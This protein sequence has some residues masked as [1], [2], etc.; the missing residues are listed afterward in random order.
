MTEARLDAPQPGDPLA[1]GIGPRIRTRRLERHLSLRELARRIDLS[2]SAVSQIE[3]GRS[4]PSV[5]TLYAIASELGISADDLLFEAGSAATP[6]M[7]DG[8]AWIG[9]RPMVQRGNSRRSIELDSGVRWDRLTPAHEEDLEFLEVEYQVGGASTSSNQLSRHPGRE[10]GVVLSGC[11]RV[12]LAFEDIE[13]N[14]GDSIAFDS[15]VPHR[16]ANAGDQNVRGIW[17]VSLRHLPL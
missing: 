15:M 1:Q 8:P 7:P 16:L 3:N 11:L 4:R 6:A 14:A 2:A 12:T 13:L 17:V 9:A 10:Y 5:G